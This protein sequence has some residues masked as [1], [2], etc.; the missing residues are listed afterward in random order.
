[1]IAAV[2]VFALLGVLGCCA[3]LFV[4]NSKLLE[5]NASQQ[6]MLT[7]QDKIIVQQQKALAGYIQEVT[8]LR[9]GKSPG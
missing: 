7:A 6:R 4:A 3:Y 1:M 8:D 9:E 5:L 2:L